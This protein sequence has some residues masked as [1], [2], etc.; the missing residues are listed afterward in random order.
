MEDFLYGVKS[1]FSNYLLISAVTGWIAAQIFKVFTGMFKE[2]S[3][4]ILTLLFSNGGMP[5]S[6]SAAVCALVTAAVIKCGLASAEVAISG[7]LA[8]IV[9]NDAMGVR[10]ET[11]KQ[12]KI[13][14]KITKELFSGKAESINTGLKELV[15]HTPFQV[16][17]GALLGITVGILMSFVML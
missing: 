3:F 1:L 4:N 5:S 12:A 6:H 7:V 2:R 8:M 16:F 15:G 14:N 17:V 9:I 11:G 13:I 10:Y